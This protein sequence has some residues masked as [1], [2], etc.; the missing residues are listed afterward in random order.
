MEFS[1][2]HAFSICVF[3]LV[4]VAITQRRRNYN[5]KDSKDGEYVYPKVLEGVTF[6]KV[7]QRMAAGQMPQTFYKWA[8]NYNKFV[9]LVPV[10]FTRVAAVVGDPEILKKILTDKSASKPTLYHRSRHIHD[11]GTNLFSENDERWY[12]ARKSIIY[13]FSPSHVRRMKDVTVE[14][15]NDF[16]KHMDSFQGNSFDVG[17]EMIKLTLKIICDAA[18]EYDMSIEEQNEFLTELEIVLKENRRGSIPLR[19]KLGK[20]IPSVRRARLGSKR[21]AALG[22]RMLVAYRQIENPTKGTVMDRI[23]NDKKY[24]S[25]KERINDML[26]LLV[27]GHDTTA[28]SLAWT[29]KEL[30]R[31]PAEQDKLRFALLNVS[32]DDR[33]NLKE[34]TNVIKEGLRLNPVAAAG[35]LRVCSKDIVIDK[36][37]EGSTPIVI[38]KGT[39]IFLSLMMCLHHPDYFHDPDSFSPSRWEVEGNQNDAY[40]PFLIGPRNCLGQSLAYAEIRT[41]LARLIAEFE[42]SI[43]DEGSNEFFATYK[44]IGCRLIAK[45]V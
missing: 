2:F 8:K 7:I 16:V 42:F 22:A 27:A 3:V 35:G 28:Y 41:V 38:P 13:S 4:S 37:S 29:L 9:Y 26:I 10:S 39:A 11:G 40:M 5:W 31:H 6:I 33:Y 23:V 14:K 32:E 21:L 1:P 18:F 30:A 24:K 12:H 43:E 15:L 44:P 19:W 45:R 34:L 36:H 20:L 17:K 25:D